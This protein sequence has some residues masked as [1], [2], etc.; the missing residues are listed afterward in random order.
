MISFLQFN[1]YALLWAI[2]MFIIAI[3]DQSQMPTLK[4]T[5]WLSFREFGH[6]FQFAFLGLMVFV[7]FEKQN[8]FPNIKRSLNVWVIGMLFFYMLILESASFYFAKQPYYI[9]DF[10]ASIVG[11]VI[12]F[13]AF[14]GIYKKKL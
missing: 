7:G 3:A 12:A 1:L 8:T 10:I 13:L 6:S 4:W 2:V 11:I 5:N 14:Y 9:P